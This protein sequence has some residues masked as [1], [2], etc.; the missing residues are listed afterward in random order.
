MEWGEHLGRGLDTAY[1][2]VLA[3]MITIILCGHILM[4]AINWHDNTVQCA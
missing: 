2:K 3:A 4:E 1:P